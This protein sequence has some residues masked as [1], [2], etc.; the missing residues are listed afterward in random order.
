MF[1]EMICDF[2]SGNIA[3]KCFL[4]FKYII[5]PLIAVVVIIMTGFYIKYLAFSVK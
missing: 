3:V 4:I 1:K 5:F 2:S